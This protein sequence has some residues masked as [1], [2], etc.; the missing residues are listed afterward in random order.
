MGLQFLSQNLVRVRIMLTKIAFELFSNTQ[1][2]MKMLKPDKMYWIVALE[3]V[4]R[5]NWKLITVFIVLCHDMNLS[6][7][8]SLVCL[9]KSCLL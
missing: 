7:N 3:L 5:L 9:V 8:F 1:D 2:V 4:R 6:L